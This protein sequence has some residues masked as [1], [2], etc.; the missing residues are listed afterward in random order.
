MKQLY[1]IPSNSIFLLI[2]DMCVRLHVYLPVLQWKLNLL[3]VDV[4]GFC[5]CSGIESI[6]FMIPYSSD[7]GGSLLPLSLDNILLQVVV[8]KA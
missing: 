1:R 6:H 3:V 8:S 4:L 5:V 7:F 2:A